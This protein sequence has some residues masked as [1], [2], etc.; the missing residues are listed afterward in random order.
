[1]VG[2]LTI[3]SRAS[4]EERRAE[5][6]SLEAPT[7]R[8]PGSSASSAP[9]IQRRAAPYIRKVSVHL[10]PPQSAELEWQGTAPADAPGSDRFTV[11]TGKGYADPGDPPG[12]CTRTCCSDA[13]T[14]CAP[15][16]NRPEKV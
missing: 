11:S 13:S 14:Q 1:P 12:T 5:Q 10:T 7:G 9:S 8:G 2:A 4:E 15:P 6:A 16:W 3:G